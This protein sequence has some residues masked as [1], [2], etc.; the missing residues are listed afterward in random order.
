[1][2]YPKYFFYLNRDVHDAADGGI[3]NLYLT[4]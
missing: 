4:T 1:M 2:F 3:T